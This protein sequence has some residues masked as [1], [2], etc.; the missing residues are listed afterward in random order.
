MTRT[1]RNIELKSRCSDLDAVRRRAEVLGARDAGVLD[2]RDTFFV[3]SHARLK[4]R[5][6][7][8][9]RAELIGYVRPD[10]AEARGSD[11][12]ICPV[13][14]PEQLAAVLTYALGASGVVIKTRHL[15]LYRHTRIHL[16]EVAG[17]GSFVEL[18]TVLGEESEA[19]ARAELHDVAT[20]LELAPEDTVPVPY[21]ELLARRS[22]RPND[23]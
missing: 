5:D 17:L 13:A 10:T 12:V 3:A 8:G 16:D 11:Y 21:V 6:L 22:R 23:D 1:R 2:Q 7:G 15:L 14:Q 18:E 4:L 9:G 19:D 20:A